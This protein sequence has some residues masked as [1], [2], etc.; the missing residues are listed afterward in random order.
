MIELRYTLVSDG[1]SDMALLPILSWL[2]RE[3]QVHCPIQAEWAELRRLPETPRKLAPKIQISLELFPCDLLFI[4]RDA[5]TFPYSR[6]K[7]EIRKALSLLNLPHPP[8]VC[9]VPVRMMEAWLLF[10]ESAI[11]RAAGNPNGQL[12]LNLPPLSRLELL[13]NPK[14]ELFELLKIASGLSGGRLKR[15][16]VRHSAGLVTRDID[17][18]SPLRILPAFTSLEDD[19]RLMVTNNRW[20]TY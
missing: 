16:D 13:P 20:D 3:N 10:S 4:H 5:E 8:A 15:F 6:R 11:R 12:T 9:V 18:F 1:S 7:T 14:R 2:L 19:V 17:D